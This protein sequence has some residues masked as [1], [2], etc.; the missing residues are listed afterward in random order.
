MANTRHNHNLVRDNLVALRADFPLPA[1]KMLQG[2]M[3]GT[4][5]GGSGIV[6]L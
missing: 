3:E 2:L 5:P 6:L 4:D 1:N